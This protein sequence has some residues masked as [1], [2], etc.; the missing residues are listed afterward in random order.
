MSNLTPPQTPSTPPTW[1]IKLEWLVPHRKQIAMGILVLAA[2]FAA[3]PI[4]QG[5]RYGLSTASSPLFLYGVI[6]SVACLALGLIC[7]SFT[8]DGVL[9]EAQKLRLLLL[10]TGGVIGLCTALLGVRA[11]LHHLSGG[12]DQG[13]AELCATTPWR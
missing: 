3:I 8:G 12:L 13:L 4:Y 10:S 11:A 2:L 7:F 1:E 5:V 9:T 6:L